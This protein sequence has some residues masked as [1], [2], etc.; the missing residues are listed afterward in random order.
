MSTKLKLGRRG[1]LGDEGGE[2]HLKM[3]RPVR[4]DRDE[5]PG[6]SCELPHSTESLKLGLWRVCKS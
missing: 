6:C 4:S 3:V 5:E 1:K 2:E